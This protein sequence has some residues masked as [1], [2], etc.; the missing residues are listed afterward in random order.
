M[1]IRQELQTT[2]GK[3]LVELFELDCTTIGG[4][5]LRFHNGV[6]EL[7]TDVVWQGNTYLRFPLEASGFE[8]NGKG[9]L[10]RPSLRVA[11]VTGLLG[12]LVRTYQDLVGCKFTRRRTMLKYL[13]AVNFV[14]GVNASADPTA[15]LPDDVY[16][17][18]RKA[19]ENKVL[20]EFELSAAFDVAGVKLPR[21]FIVQNICPWTYRGGECGYTG[22]AYFDSTDTPTPSLSQDSCGKRM[23]SCKA[24]FGEHAELPFGGFPAAGLVR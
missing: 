16:F 9:Q 3:Q 17:V 12:A 6:N 21:R 10:P 15:A 24:R 23:A 11:N 13:D 5:V 4:S 14:G 22:T 1:T 19:T 2:G 8:Y 20:I 7:G 18:D